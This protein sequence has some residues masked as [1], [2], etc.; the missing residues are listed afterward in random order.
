MSIR[1]NN[2]EKGKSVQFINIKDI[3]TFQY[4]DTLSQV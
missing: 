4:T 1:I 3:I 2:G